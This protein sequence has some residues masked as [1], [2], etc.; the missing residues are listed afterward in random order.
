MPH[1][2]THYKKK[3]W[4]NWGNAIKD[5]I[6]KYQSWQGGEVSQVLQ[7]TQPTLR[8]WPSKAWS[9]EQG[10]LTVYI[11]GAPFASSE[12]GPWKLYFPRYVGI[13]VMQQDVC[14]FQ[15]CYGMERWNDMPRMCL[16]TL[17]Q[18]KMRLEKVRQMWQHLGSH[19][20]W[21]MSI[22]EL[23]ECSSFECLEIFIINYLKLDN[24]HCHGNVNN[25]LTQMDIFADFSNLPVHG[26][27]LFLACHPL[28]SPKCRWC[29]H[30]PTTSVCC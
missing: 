4:N 22:W 9:R 12:S 23:N 6:F 21:V 18:E 17:R 1:K 30:L 25:G 2:Q 15:R 19:G 3:V 28:P 27:C 29:D 26:I 5:W 20:D 14:I 7:L 8:C 13:V 24:S 10:F 11:L 16:K